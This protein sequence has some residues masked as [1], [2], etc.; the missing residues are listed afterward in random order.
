VLRLGLLAASRIAHDA[1]I[2][3]ALEVEGVDVVAVAARELTRAQEAAGRWSLRSSFGSYAEL[4]TADD[5]D[6]VYIGLPAA[7]HRPWAI[8]AIEAGKHVLCEKPLAANGDDARRLADAA[9]AS[10]VVVMEAYHWRYHPFAGQIHDVLDSGVLGSIERVEASFTLPDG[11]I[12]TGDI[13][14]D[15]ALGGGALMDLGCYPLQ[16]VR[17]AVGAEP[18]VVSAQ[19]VCPVPEVDGELTAELSWPGGVTGRIHASMMASEAAAELAVT[20]SAGVLRAHNPL[21]PQ[22]GASLEVVGAG[23]RVESVPERTTTYFHQLRA[24]RDAIATG[25]PFPTTI[26]DGVRV[27]ELIDRCYRAAGLSPRP[28]WP[29]TVQ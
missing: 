29:E 18:D 5:V 17:F 11:A 12:A 4:V 23:E 26:D 16:W 2:V 15:L 28:T 9:R 1:V 25:A 20:G 27:M 3:P 6:A 7:L 21:A 24:F 19:A 14:W 13:R 22:R 10:D 8:A